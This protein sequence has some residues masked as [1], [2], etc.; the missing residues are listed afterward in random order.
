MYV[1]FSYKITHFVS[2]RQE[3]WPPWEYIV[4]IDLFHCTN[5]VH[6]MWSRLSQFLIW[7]RLVGCKTWHMA[8]MGYSCFWFA[9][10]LCILCLLKY[11]FNL[12]ATVTNDVCYIFYRYSAFHFVQNTWATWTI[13]FFQM[14]FFFFYFCTPKLHER[15]FCSLV[16]MMLVGSS[17]KI[18]HS[19]IIR[20]KYSLNKQMAMFAVI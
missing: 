12:F 2:I 14:L 8:S 1:R 3:T 18:L 6:G 5:D 10:I 16:Q 7:L 20:K 13:F 11:K 19:I 4:S 9:E 15:M 17:T